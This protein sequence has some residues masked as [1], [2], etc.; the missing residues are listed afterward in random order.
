MS[1]AGCPFLAL[2]RQASVHTALTVACVA[3]AALIPWLLPMSLMGSLAF[4][5]VAVA[6]VL[7]AAWRAGWVG[8]RFGTQSAVWDTDGEWRVTVAPSEVHRAVLGSGTRVTS[9][10]V[11]LHWETP[12]GSRQMVL[13]RWL[14]VRQL[15]QE[16]WRRLL[17]RLRLQGALRRSAAGELGGASGGA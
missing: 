7:P 14:F 9:S 10:I 2:D 17:V 16:A 4:A 6:V 15:D 12:I 13:I 8:G 1:S 3:L 5:S 11:W